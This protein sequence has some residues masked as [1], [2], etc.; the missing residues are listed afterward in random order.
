[1]PNATPGQLAAYVRGIVEAMQAVPQ[2]R[3]VG[4][5]SVIPFLDT[6]GIIAI[7][8]LIEGRAAPAPGEEPSAAVNVA[9][10]GYFAAMRVE[11]LDGRLFDHSD[12]GT[13]ALVAVVSQAFA[14][15]HWTG[16]SPIGEH[17]RFSLRG[18][19]ARVEVVG[20]VADT[21]Y[22][23]LDR[24]VTEEVFVPHAQMP[25]NDMTLVARASG[26]PVPLVGAMRSALRAVAPRQAVYRTATMSEL[27]ARSLNERRFMLALVLGFALL[28]LALAAS[29]VYGV[30]SAVSTQRLKEYGLR[31]ALGASRGQILRMV[32]REGALITGSGVAIGA[33]GALAAGRLLRGFLFEVGPTDLWTLGSVS[34]LLGAA[35]GIAC[36]LPALRATRVSPLVALRD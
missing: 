7:P 32:A 33:A 26:D 13:R 8:I 19:E 25:L 30:M 10:P 20:I 36:L 1:V 4:A 15:R 18:Q 22:E 34:A 24:P 2:M 11:R 35:A 17:L 21:R 9:T 31:V 27:V 23:S 14:K 12:D 28:A 5:A 16:R 6:T 3:E 29:G